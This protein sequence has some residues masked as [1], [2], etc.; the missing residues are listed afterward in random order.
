MSREGYTS[1]EDYR[2]K[3]IEELV[4]EFLVLIGEDPDREGLRDTPSRVAKMW[5]NELSIGYFKKP[6]EV[7]KMFSYED[8]EDQTNYKKIR[9]VII[10]SG[11]S[12]RTLC[13]HHLLPIIGVASIAYIPEDKILGFSKF[14][15]IVDIF[16]RRLQLQERLTDQIADFIMEHLRP[17][18]VIVVIKGFHLCA[19]HRGVEEP[20]LMLTRSVRGIFSENDNLRNEVL[21]V[22]YQDLLSSKDLEHVLMKMF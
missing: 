11:I 14:A 6:E 1:S 22:I 20:M 12:V 17:R 21:N 9:D 10:V 13:E 15:R 16:S 5:V 2:R 19:F 8:D 4:R 3:R 18:G 7:L